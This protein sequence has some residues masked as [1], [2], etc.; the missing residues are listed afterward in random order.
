MNYALF[1]VVANTNIWAVLDRVYVI[2]SYD[3]SG[4]Q[5][6]FEISITATW[7]CVKIIIALF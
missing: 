5:S 6:S 2:H 4:F 1:D 3:H 7:T